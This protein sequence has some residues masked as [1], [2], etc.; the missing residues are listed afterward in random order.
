MCY[1]M[2]IRQLRYFCAIAEC[3]SFSEASRRCYLSQSAISQQIKLLEEEL[4]TVLFVRTPHKVLLT[5]GGKV[6]LPMARDLVKSVDMCKE[7]MSD[8]N[9]MLCGELNIGM[10]FSMESYL[11]RFVIM[12]MKLYPK[13]QL[14]IYYKTIPELIKLLRNG[15]LDMAFSII[16]SGEVDWVDS[17]P[18]LEY[19][20]CAVMRDTH[21]L[22]DRPEISFADLAKQNI[23]LPEAGIADLN[24][25]EKY[26]KPDAGKMNV[27]ATI[28]DTCAILNLLKRTNYISVLT[29]NVVEGIDELIALPI[30]E[31]RE[32]IIS[33]AHTVKGVYVKKSARVFLDMIKGAGK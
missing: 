29:E 16:V 9:K 17:V 21:P 1:A 33:Y 27:R 19:R 26:L 15:D 4:D 32:P 10:T 12:F 31:L 25:I 11:R 28:N 13:V 14:N 23:V 7:R 2:E 3:R 24:A 30:S 6:L 5:E 22:H 20:H 8:V 18:I